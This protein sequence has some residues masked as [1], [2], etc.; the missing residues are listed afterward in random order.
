MKSI[1]YVLIIFIGF[2]IS[3]HSGYIESTFI[4]Q[5]Q[6]IDETT[7]SNLLSIFG[8]LPLNFVANH[9]Q[10]PEEVIYHAQS[11]GTTIYCTEQGL[12]FGFV[13]GSISLKFSEDRRVKPEARDELEGKVNY[14]IG[15]DLTLW[16]TNISTFKKVIYREVYPGIDLVYSGD[17]RRLK[18][19]FYLQPNSNPNQIQ[20][21]Y[22][23]IESL[24]VDDATG[25][26]VIQTPWGE[27]R[28][29]KPVAY[30]EIKGM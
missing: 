2:L 28:D 8:K 23:G 27:M 18:Y 29:A 1:S 30:Q 9:G 4:S 10:F 25:E 24:C 20:M 22:D 11:E 3:N 5:E 16:R 19:T 26:L 13:E 21:I 7:K 17:Q 6:S 12:T 14:F 15:K